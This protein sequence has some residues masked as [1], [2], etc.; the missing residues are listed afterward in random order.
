MKDQGT[1][2][3]QWLSVWN[4]VG[5]ER[6]SAVR[7]KFEC[8]ARL[9]IDGYPEAETV[10]FRGLSH[11]GAVVEIRPSGPFLFP[12]HTVGLGFRTPTYGVCLARAVV[13]RAQG[14]GTH[15]LFF[16]ACNEALR[17]LQ[18]NAIREGFPPR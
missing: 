3:R 18:F 14:D 11:T 15:A 12:D 16:T 2:G 6:R 1:L 5:F 13:L 7:S 9:H 8:H 10:V 17:R 4:T